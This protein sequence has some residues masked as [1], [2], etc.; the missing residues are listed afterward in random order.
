MGPPQLHRYHF[1]TEL[2]QTY[3]LLVSR[4]SQTGDA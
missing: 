2:S 1:K 4:L 3:R